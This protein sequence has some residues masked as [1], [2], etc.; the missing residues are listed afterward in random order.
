MNPGRGESQDISMAQGT[1]TTWG[2][3]STPMD[4]ILPLNAERKL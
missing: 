1:Q 2:K 3:G 4:R